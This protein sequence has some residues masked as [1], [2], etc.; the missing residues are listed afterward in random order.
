VSRFFLGGSPLPLLLAAILLALIARR[1]TGRRRALFLTLFQRLSDAT[2][3]VVRWIL[4]IA[5]LG[6]LA[7]SF[8]LARST[9]GRAMSLLF[10]FVLIISGVTL[11]FTLLLYPVTAV[12]GGIS[13]RQFAQAVAPAQLVA[14]ST[15]SSLAALPALIEAGRDRLGLPVAATGFVIP[16]AM[17]TVK[18][19]RMTTTIVTLLFLAH[20]FGLPL[21]A[22]RLVSFG[23]T[24][25]LLSL[26]VAGLPGRGPEANV[27]PAY[28]AAGVPL[29]GVVI[30]EAVDAI[31]DIFKTILN[32]TSI[33]SAAAILAPRSR[34]GGDR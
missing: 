23:G 25:L 1:F 5:P 26:I 9:G 22:E 13:M 27:L 33:L 32:V 16:F 31:P 8:G 11:L 30:L 2:M 19:S 12:L 34:E 24:V 20:A 28:T 3:R 18:V 6:V 4:L 21:G 29:E 17:A 7:L 14:A 15:R 10:A